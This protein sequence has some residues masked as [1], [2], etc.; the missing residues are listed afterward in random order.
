MQLVTV[1]AWQLQEFLVNVRYTR[2]GNLRKSP[3]SFSFVEPEIKCF[4][5]EL[6]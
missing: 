6:V 2:L 1:S 5:E 4:L 3:F